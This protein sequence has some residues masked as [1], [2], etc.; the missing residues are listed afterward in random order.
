MKLLGV[1]IAI[2]CFFSSVLSATSSDTECRVNVCFAIDGSGSIGNSGFTQATDFAT[3]VMSLL[4]GIANI[5]FGAVQYASRFYEIS[6]I[7]DNRETV[8]AAV[9][10]AKPKGTS[11][12][13]AA[14]IDGCSYVLAHSQTEVPI[15]VLI[16]D[17]RNNSG[18][19]PVQA[20]DMFRQQHRN[21]K[22]HAVG[23]GNS[24]TS[25]LQAIADKKQIFTVADYLEVTF[26]IEESVSSR[27]DLILP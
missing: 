21:G 11:T 6:R 4:V 13:V 18:Y 10:N 14:G 19:D 8:F 26:L 20:A 22:I 15:I 1:I 2:A 7:S 23:V 25:L 3:D 27:C 24:D 16:G 9:S 17:G 12:S 5:R